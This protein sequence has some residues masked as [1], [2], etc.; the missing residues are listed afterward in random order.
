MPAAFALSAPI[1]TTAAAPSL[2]GDELPAVTLPVGSNTGF[3]A[4]SFSSDVSARGPSSLSTVMSRQTSPS[5]T[6]V[7]TGRISAVKSPRVCAATA[8]WWLASA[9]AS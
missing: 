7:F 3:S 4:A 2:S 1:N 6:R 8:F 9:N 5:N